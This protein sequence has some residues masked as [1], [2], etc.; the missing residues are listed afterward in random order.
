MKKTIESDLNMSQNKQNK[1]DWITE[2][3]TYSC[4][5]C[6][7]SYVNKLTDYKLECGC[8]CHNKKMLEQQVS[9]PACS[10]TLRQNQSLQPHG[11]LIYD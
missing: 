11:V 1:V 3:L 4:V 8:K 10:N 5:D 6:P 7:G 9:R 2:C